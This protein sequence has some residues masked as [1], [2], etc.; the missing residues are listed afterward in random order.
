[1]SPALAGGFLTAAPPGKPP[2]SPLDGQEISICLTGALM[3]GRVHGV[4]A[5]AWARLRA[6][7]LWLK[8]QFTFPD[9]LSIS[10][11]LTRGVPSKA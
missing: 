10:G 7:S 2:N 1:M 9:I 3:M 5:V 4:L 8:H 6:F 11:T